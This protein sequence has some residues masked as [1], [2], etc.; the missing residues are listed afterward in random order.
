LQEP[1]GPEKCHYLDFQQNWQRNPH[2]GLC[3]MDKMATVGD[4]EQE[5]MLSEVNERSEI[6]IEDCARNWQATTFWTALW[7]IA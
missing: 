5:A 3:G 6:L 1:G 4:Y 7:L 2:R